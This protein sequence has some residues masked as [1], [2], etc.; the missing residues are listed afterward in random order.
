[1]NPRGLALPLLLGAALLAGA[2]PAR[3]QGSSDPAWVYFNAGQQAYA[4]GK[5]AYAIQAF[6]DAY[7]LSQKPGLIFSIAQAYRKQYTDQKSSKDLRKAVENYRKYIETAPDGP[8]RPD[9]IAALEEL[10]PMLAKLGEQEPE[11]SAPAPDAP[12]AT[13]LVVTVSV[14]TA[15]I[16]VDGAPPMKAPY[17]GEVKHGKRVVRITAEGYFPET[18]E[19]PVAE[20]RIN[21]LDIQ[22]REMPGQIQVNAMNGAVVTVDGRPM[23]VTP[24]SRP[25]EVPAGVH[26]VAVTHNGYKP[27]VQDISVKRGEKRQL[28]VDLETTKQRV[29]SY[30]FMGAGAISAGVGLI[31][32]LGAGA[33]EASA[34]EIEDQRQGSFI[35][36]DQLEE[37]K[38]R[39]SSRDQLRGASVA[40]F[41]AAGLLGGAGF[42]LFLFDTPSVVAPP[43]RVE[44]KPGAPSAPA[45]PASE[46][47]L[48]GLSAAPTWSPGF[49]GGTV[50]GHF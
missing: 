29:V 11:A 39:L 19:V 30:V 18:R 38:D 36:V 2:P 4:A 12:A 25:V 10:E 24:L 3:A 13:S 21:P 27:F 45:S 44:Q 22:L 26:S 42:L 16:S 37:Y 6:Q 34:Q 7:R 46:D 15:M 31:A 40:S 1:M 41:S 32:A 28:V 49:V 43:P 48:L 17:T 23:G 9:A 47:R 8:R 50:R 14:P 35:S 33:A 5:Y 20:G